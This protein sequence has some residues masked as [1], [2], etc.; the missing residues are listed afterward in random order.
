[1]L[2]LK[3]TIYKILDQNQVNIIRKIRDGERKSEKFH[4]IIS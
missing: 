3:I 1:M 4:D 2:K